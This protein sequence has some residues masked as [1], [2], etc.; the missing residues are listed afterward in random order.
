MLLVIE[1]RSGSAVQVHWPDVTGSDRPDPVGSCIRTAQGLLPG[2]HLIEVT[3]TSDDETLNVD[4][5]E[6]SGP[7]SERWLVIDKDGE[8]DLNAPAGSSSG[9]VC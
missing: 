9:E 4:V 3:S 7:V 2:H 5:P 6:P 8:I 1:N